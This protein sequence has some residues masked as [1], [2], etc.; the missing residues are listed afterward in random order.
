[1]KKILSDIL[2]V[3]ALLIASPGFVTIAM[4]FLLAT[5]FFFVS[6]SFAVVNSELDDDDE[7]FY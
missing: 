7:V 2:F 1:M 6:M 5:P 3:A 4:G